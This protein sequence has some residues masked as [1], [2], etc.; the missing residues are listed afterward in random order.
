MDTTPGEMERRILDAA[1]QRLQDLAA[2]IQQRYGVAART[3]ALAGSLL[4]ELA[5]EADSLAAGLLV[6]GARGKASFGI[7]CWERRRCGC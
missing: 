7:F 4:A 5:R 2:A 3:H 6:C 1:R